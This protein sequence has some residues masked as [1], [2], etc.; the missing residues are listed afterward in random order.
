MTYKCNRI[1]DVTEKPSTTGFS[2][3]PFKKSQPLLP[4]SFLLHFNKMGINIKGN[5]ALYVYISIIG[6]YVSQSYSYIFCSISIDLTKLAV[7]THF[8]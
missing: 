4:F 3:L 1:T 2:V 6:D 8:C 7:A 5:I